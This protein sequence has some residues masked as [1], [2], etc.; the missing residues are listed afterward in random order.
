MDF[1]N[2][3]RSSACLLECCETGSE[4]FSHYLRKLVSPWPLHHT[5]VVILTIWLHLALFCVT[6]KFCL[7]CNVTVVV[8][9]DKM[10]KVM[11]NFRKIVTCC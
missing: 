5:V 8:Y 2:L 1:S 3:V 9:R 6:I 11:K 7:V 10:V 4:I